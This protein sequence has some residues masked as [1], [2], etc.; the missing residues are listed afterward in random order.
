VTTLLSHLGAM[1]PDVIV[2]EVADGLY[3]EE[4]RRLVQSA[5]FRRHVDGVLYACSD[6]AG[7]CAGIELLRSWGYEPLALS[8]TL[9]ASPLATAEAVAATGLEVI[10]LERFLDD[11]TVP[12]LLL[13]GRSRAAGV[14]HG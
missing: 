13:Q 11:S 3:Q 12:T 10:T 7:A 8:G 5:M 14:Q 4:T 2:I 6:A 9:S 1:R